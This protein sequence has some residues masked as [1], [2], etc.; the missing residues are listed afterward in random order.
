VPCDALAAKLD[1]INTV[2]MGL[3][4]TKSHIGIKQI[5]HSF[6]QFSKPVND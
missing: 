4:Q 1:L 6:F 5:D 2:R 3:K